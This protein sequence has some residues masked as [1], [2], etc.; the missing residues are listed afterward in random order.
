[1]TFE[2]YGFPCHDGEDSAERS[3]DEDEEGDD[4]VAAATSAVHNDRVFL[5]SICSCICICWFCY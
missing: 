5:F 4:E 1:M 3:G 2:V